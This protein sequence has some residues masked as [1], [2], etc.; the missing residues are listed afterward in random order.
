MAS[1]SSAHQYEER[2]SNETDMYTG[3]WT[4]SC[5]RNAGDKVHQHGE[6]EEEARECLEAIQA[7]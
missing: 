3:A 2:S 7:T 5:S 1:P 4:A 6:T